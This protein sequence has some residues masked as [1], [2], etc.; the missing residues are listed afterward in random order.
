MVHRQGGTGEVELP[1]QEIC[2]VQGR[3]HAERCSKLDTLPP[4]PSPGRAVSTHISTLKPQALDQSNKESMV[5]GSSIPR[6]LVAFRILVVSGPLQGLGLLDVYPGSVI[7][8]QG[9]RGG[10]T[11]R[12]SRCRPRDVSGPSK[13]T[14]GDRAGSTKGFH[15]CLLMSPISV[16]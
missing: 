10:P 6:R 4:P 16:N 5:P 12:K 14:W 7:P 13:P 15:N 3:T 8:N 9:L 1:C 11:V 2:R